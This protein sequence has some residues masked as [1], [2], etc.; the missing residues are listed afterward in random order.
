MLYNRKI[1]RLL[2]VVVP[3]GLFLY[4]STRPTMRLRADMPAQF[5]DASASA[6]S[7]QRAAEADLARKY[8]ALAISA[9]QWRYTYGSPLPDT[10]P[11]DFRLFG[12]VPAGSEPLSASRFRYW[13]RLQLVWLSPDAWKVTHAWSTQW[14]TDPLMRAG[15][16]F[17]RS[18]KDFVANP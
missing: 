1:D 12:D 15:D 14:L 6:S 2:I 4:A 7:R 3:I 17:D 16:W 18:F 10:P 13:H 5:T 9:V 8:W 11:D